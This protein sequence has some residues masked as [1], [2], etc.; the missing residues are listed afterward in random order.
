L[1]KIGKSLETDKKSSFNQNIVGTH[2]QTTNTPTFMP[3]N[4]QKTCKI[5]N[6]TRKNTKK[7]G[8]PPKT[9]PSTK[10]PVKI[11]PNNK[12]NH[13]YASTIHIF[14]KFRVKKPLKT[15]PSPIS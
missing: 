8:K 11:Q 10:K 15:T 6:K 5:R 14:T 13:P 9:T 1:R 4:G 12:Q 2:P 7:H 3:L